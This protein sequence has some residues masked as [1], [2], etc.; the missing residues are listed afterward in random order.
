[1]LSLHIT[2]YSV[3]TG[4]AKQGNNSFGSVTQ[5]VNTL[6]AEH[7]FLGMEVCLD[8]GEVRLVNRLSLPVK[9][10]CL[11]VCNLEVMR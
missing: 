5:S 2:I 6:T 8:H 10:I 4:S 11:C 7:C 9:A 1:M 3:H